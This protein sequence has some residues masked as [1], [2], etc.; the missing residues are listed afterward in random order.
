L[1]V[2]NLNCSDISG[3]AARAAH[4]IHHALRGIGVDSRMWVREKENDDWTTEKLIAT[5]QQRRWTKLGSKIGRLV[6]GLL[7]TENPV[8]HSPAVLKSPWLTKI[9]GCDA[10]L[11]HLHW[12]NGEMLSIGDIGSIRKPGV[13]TLHD[14]W[15]FC[16]AEHYTTD[17]RWRDGYAEHNRP[18]Y[19][20]GCDINRWVW[21]RKLRSWKRPIQIVTP[22]HWLGDCV[23]QSALMHDWPISVIPNPIDTDIWQP[24][25][26]PTARALLGLPVDVPLLL[27]GAMGGA[28][29]PRKGFD[30]LQQALNHLRG[31]IPGLELVVFGQS[32]PQ[33]PVDL[34]FPVH[35]LGHLHDDLALRILYS[36]VDVMAIPSRQD[37]LPNTGVES[38]ACGTPVIAFNT[39]GLPDIVSHQKT[40]YLAKAYDA[41]EFAQGIQWVLGDGARHALLRTNARDDAVT[42]FSYP[43]VA[44]Q[45]LQVY[46]AVI[47]SQKGQVRP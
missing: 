9:N 4:R 38:L 8:L 5:A 19:E 27:F 30:L 29:D 46:D 1:K 23:R 24:V 6:R 34:G 35:F 36:A 10:D 43:V 33:Q 47:Q 37:N 22:S 32:A 16:G 41:E 21:K 11:V 13:W 42:R 25:A 26:K 39:C 45:Y 12:V 28:K 40:G 20:K 2:I 44:Q 14:M 18:N 3:G 31:E 17:F 15:A 7:A